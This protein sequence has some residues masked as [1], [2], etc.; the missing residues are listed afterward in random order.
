MIAERGWVDADE[1]ERLTGTRREPA[2]GPWVV[3]PEALDAL[4]RG[5]LEKVEAA[6]PLG[7]DIAS[8]DEHERAVIEADE[9]VVV[10]AGRVLLATAHDPYPTHPY[11]AVLAAAPFAPPSPS[12]AGVADG[13]VRELVRR[14]LVVKEGGLVFA[15]TAVDQAAA[16][17]ATLLATSPEGC[18]SRISVRR[19]GPAGAS[20]WPCWP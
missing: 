20:R 5:L 12:D 19:S 16:V 18:R 7:L 1:L 17:V 6:A 15:S 3:D 9:D 2:I 10:N 4:R 13:E 14:G 11:L 8:L